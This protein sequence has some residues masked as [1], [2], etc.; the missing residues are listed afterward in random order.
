MIR[1]N[2]KTPS[3]MPTVSPV[4]NLNGCRTSCPLGVA[5]SVLRRLVSE[6][7]ATQTPVCQAMDVG[8]LALRVVALHAVERGVVVLVVEI[9]VTVEVVEIGRIIEPKEPS[10]LEAPPLPPLPPSSPLPTTLT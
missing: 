6:I 4:L 9:A 3:A 1:Q 10:A 7:V 2:A 8:M 5:V